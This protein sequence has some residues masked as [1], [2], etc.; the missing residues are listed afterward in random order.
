M[1]VNS[2][3]YTYIFSVI[4]VVVV[5]AALSIAAT[6]LKPFQQANVK[7][8]KMQDILRSINVKVDRTAAEESFQQYITEMAVIKNGQIC[9]DCAET[10]FDIDM[11]EQVGKPAQERT[12]PIYVAD[13]DGESY[14][15]IPLRGRGLW[16]PIWGYISLKSDAATVYGATFDH[17]SE[18]PG[19]GAEINTSK[20]QENFKNKRILDNTGTFTSITI[21]K[22]DAS[23]DYEVDGISGGTITSDGLGLMLKE[24]IEPYIDYLKARN[25]G[26]AQL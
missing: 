7:L 25:S 20:F 10:A 21:K 18:T 9:A 14:F 13:K 22:G 17:K 5:A 1:D 24:G 12:L 4:L 6:S 15:I 2:N 11:A 3:K 23:G 16:G 8:E 26:V 19:L